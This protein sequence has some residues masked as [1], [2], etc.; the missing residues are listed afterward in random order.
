MLT[1]GTFDGVHKGHQQII[2]RINEQ[3]HSNDGES[4]LLTF[5]PHPRLVINPNDTSLK[6]LNTL[7]EK[8]L[9][10][11]KYGVDNLII[12]PFSKEFS[13]LTA[14]QYVNDFLLDTI[15]PKTIVIGYDHR[16]GNNREGDIELL[17]ELANKRG[18]EVIEI[19]KQTVDD[20]AV[21]ST[22]VRK[23][24]Q[25][26]HIETATNL[27]GH[28]FSVEGV[29]IHG[30]K[31]GKAL[32][33]PTANIDLG[34]PNKLIPAQGVYAV[35]VQ[36]GDQFYGGM[37]NIGTNPTFDG[38]DQT[39]E[40]HIFDFDRDIYGSR[41]TVSFVKYLRAEEH[42]DEVSALILKMQEDEAIS[43]KLLNSL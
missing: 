25:E 10:L 20:I 26:G 42:F 2:Q 40:V 17:T 39:I 36:L 38:A 33:Y 18:V 3:A 31:N 11:D 15:K 34:N 35:K 12:N 37:L 9:L 21:S 41:L 43:R 30:K 14:E 28:H 24:L 13:Q 6:L 4:I 19:S 32:G 22:K 16:F 5:H 8:V 27:L 23:A 7:E 1:I 29:V